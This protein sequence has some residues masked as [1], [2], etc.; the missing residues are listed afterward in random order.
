MNKLQIFKNEQFGEIRWIKVNEKDYAVGIDVAKSLGYKNPNDAIARHCKGYVKHAVPTN[1]GEQQMNIISEGDIYRLTAKSELPGAE[2]F[3]SWIFDEVL[4][5]IRQTGGYIP[6][7]ENDSDEDIMAK[8]LL[9]ATRKIELKDKAIA[10]KDKQLTLQQPKVI[11]ADAVTASYTSILV[12]DLAKILK[13][14]GFDIGANRLFEKLRI[15]GYLICR[16]GTDYNMPTQR[17][18]ELGL[19]QIKETSIAHSNGH[20][21]IS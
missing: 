8:A 12:G 10:D 14:N 9:I 20:V 3:E 6:S 18:M 11:F 17:S 21:S 19:F 4:P 15:M 7:N 16:K 13:Q 1:S 5:Q 2:K